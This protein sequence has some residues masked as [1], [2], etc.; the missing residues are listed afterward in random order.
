[1]SYVAL[2]CMGKSDFDAMKGFRANGFFKRTLGL[3]AVASSPTL[4]PGV[5]HLA[6]ESEYNFERTLPMAAS[7]VS[8]PLLVRADSGFCSLQASAIYHSVGPI[9][10]ARD[11]LHHQVEPAQRASEGHCSRGGD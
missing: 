5:Q 10:Y 3:A 1:M 6:A 7:P 8:S 4:R 9:H 2:L 11:G